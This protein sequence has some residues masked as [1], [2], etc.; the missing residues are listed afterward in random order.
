MLKWTRQGIIRELLNREAAGRSLAP[1]GP[2]GCGCMLYQAA[3]RIFGSWRNTLNAAGI[4]PER[5]NLRDPWTPARI[6]SEI[7]ALARRRRQL[8]YRDLRDHHSYLVQSTRR[9]F[10]SWPRALMAAGIEPTRFRRNKPWTQERILEAILQRAL[11]NAPLGSQTVR[12]HTLS[13][14]AVRV[15]GS[16]PN[17]LQAAGL[18]PVTTSG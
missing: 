6:I 14:A 11:A 13:E 18:N 17:A 9:C 12:P 10:G 2:D 4:S 1:S 8:F 15:F 16:W 3:T 7:R 5:A